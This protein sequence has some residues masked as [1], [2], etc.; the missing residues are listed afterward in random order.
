M[1]KTFVIYILV[2]CLALIPIS[3]AVYAVFFYSPNIF[4]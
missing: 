1:K 3:R 2:F 4:N